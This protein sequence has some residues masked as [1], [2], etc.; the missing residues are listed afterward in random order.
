MISSAPAYAEGYGPAEPMKLERVWDPFEMMYVY[1]AVQQGR[2]YQPRS[3]RY[4]SALWKTPM[5]IAEAYQRAEPRISH[6]QRYSLTVTE[7]KEGTECP[8]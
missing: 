2:L 8:T 3:G 5:E 1:R 7:P 6:S 4:E